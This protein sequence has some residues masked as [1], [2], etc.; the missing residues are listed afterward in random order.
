MKRYKERVAAR[1]KKKMERMDV[2]FEENKHPRGKDGKFV[3][4]NG[5][6]GTGGSAVGGA[7]GESRAI[8]KTPKTDREVYNIIKD[9]RASNKDEFRKF[10]DGKNEYRLSWEKDKPMGAGERWNTKAYG[11]TCDR[12]ILFKNQ[13]IVF[14][15][16][17]PATVSDI[18]GIVKK[19]AKAMR[20]E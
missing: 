12:V 7:K 2:S 10:K 17:S 6:Q 15:A 11:K 18:K 9:M 19:V 20:G 16:S 1:I 3:S 8:T 14:S 13:D 5:E 4:G